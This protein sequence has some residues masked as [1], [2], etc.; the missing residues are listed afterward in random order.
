MGRLARGRPGAR[1]RV[2]GGK[3]NKKTRNGRVILDSEE[4]LHMEFRG[5]DNSTFSNTD[6][7]AATF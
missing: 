6:D 7:T 4:L 3:N 2:P 1:V 5:W